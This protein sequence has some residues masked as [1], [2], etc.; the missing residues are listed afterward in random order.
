MC[1]SNIRYLIVYILYN[2][3]LFKSTKY[4][5]ETVRIISAVPIEINHI[6]C[7]LSNQVLVGIN[8]MTDLGYILVNFMVWNK[9]KQDR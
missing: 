1:S 6:S 9:D 2:E 4:L 5:I 8:K 3:N 7:D